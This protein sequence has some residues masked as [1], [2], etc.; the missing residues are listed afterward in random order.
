[1]AAK[2]LVKRS[3]VSGQAPNT[4][5]LTTGE[6]AL[7]LTD[8]IMYGSNGTVVFEIGANVSSLTVNDYSFPAADGANGQ[9]LKTDGNGNITFSTPVEGFTTGDVDTHLNQ[10]SATSNQVLSWDGS[11]YSWVNQSGGGSVTITEFLY[12]PTSNTS[13]FSGTDENGLVLAYSSGEEDVYLNGIK[14]IA[15]DDYAATNST[16]VTL[17]ANAVNGDTVQIV[18]VSGSSTVL[19][20]QYTVSANQTIFTGSD[21]NSAVLNYTPGREQV[22]L[23]GVKLI[24][25]DDYSRPNTSHII[26]TANAV[27]TDTLEAV[28][29]AGAGGDL[30]EAVGYASS[31][32]DLLTINTF[33]KTVYRTA[34][35]IIQANTSDSYAASEALVIHDGTTAYVTE[36]GTLYSNNNL[37]TVSGDISSNDV[38]LNVTPT[39][40]GT[41]FKVKRIAI[42][43]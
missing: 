5:Q 31:N 36:Y 28:V 29:F 24:N 18:K 25:G 23:N 9:V 13:V 41:T 34:K 32:T 3:S 19:E 40:S 14:L 35:Y 12:K 22:F 15:G 38:R 39:G 16:A 20:Y 27:A 17:Q 1:M 43:V 33:N 11:D 7:N 30:T 2:F 6:L 26:L 8:G 42:K 37:Y 21:D 10:S 4:S